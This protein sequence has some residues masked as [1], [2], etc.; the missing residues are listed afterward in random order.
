VTDAPG[1]LDPALPRATDA[2]AFAAD[3]FGFLTR[4]RAALG[5]AVVLRDGGPVFSRAADCPGVVAVF[6]AAAFRTVLADLETFG[7]PVS[8]ARQLGLPPA[9][10]NLTRGLHSMR[11]DEHAAQ[12]R[13]V[14][15]VLSDG[16]ADHAAQARAVVAAVTQR[17]RPGKT[18]ALLDA[19]R[20]LARALSARV[21]FGAAHAE[22]AGLVERLDTFFVV[23]REV[24]SPRAGTG[25]AG[26][27]LLVALGAPLDAELRGYVRACRA[28]AA[29][30]GICGRLA[31]TALPEDAVVAHANVLFISSTEP[32]AVA[33]T[34]ILLVLSQQPALR[35]ALRAQVA[36]AGGLARGA[37]LDRVIAECLRLL[38]PNA[39][40]ARVTTCPVRLGGAALP[41]GTEIALCPF[42]AHRDAARFPDPDRFLPE[43][44]ATVRPS[45]FEYLP[46][47]AGSHACAGRALASA[48]IAAVLAA[49][50]ARHELVLAD[51]QAIDWRLHIQ[52]LPRV[53]PVMRIRSPGS[54]ARPGA[55]WRGAVAE[56]VRLGPP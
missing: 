26:R 51:D 18:L 17:W 5:D 55:A 41:A 49:L 42:V 53:D 28:G 10:A 22:L 14:T 29:A 23:R 36:T 16:I 56:I 9:L 54:R 25:E 11:G 24:S 30:G 7:M 31:G 35:G 20:G 27:A 40:M 2:A 38:P 8:A 19:M 45:P 13:I 44:W 12:R 37:L 47:G 1:A 48:L 52:L 43:R 15:A 4:A 50:L 3:P 39:M 6:G 33:L 32:I 21:L 46:F 34:W